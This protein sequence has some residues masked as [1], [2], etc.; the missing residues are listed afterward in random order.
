MNKKYRRTIK[1]YT[2][3]LAIL[4]FFAAVLGYILIAEY[5]VEFSARVTPSYARADITYLVQKSSWTEED[6]TLLYRQ[7]GLGKSALDALK[8]ENGDILAF[9]D[10]L[11]YE[12][13][14]EHE[15]VVFT[16]K[17][18]K[19]SYTLSESGFAPIAPLETGDVL[20][21]SA[22]HSFGWRN[23]HAAIVTDEYGT[24]LESVSLGKNSRLADSVDWFRSSP[25]FIV[26]RLKGVSKEDR[27]KIGETAAKTLNNVPYSLT[28]GIFSPKDQGPDAKET[29]CAH[30][31][32]QAYY[33]FGYDI[34]SNGGPLVVPQ[35]IALSD[36][37]EVVQVYG[38]D[39]DTLW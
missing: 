28:V 24:L 29:Q 30:L 2:V 38:F 13:E 32:W 5:T 26:L 4:L 11:F 3:F 6:Y 1:L 12:G 14:I 9:Q 33:N 34:D 18:D 22:C 17:R 36:L 31:V 37:F 23:G 7:T 19:M 8:R 15:S 27:A 25:N 10:A 39:V 20:V 16:T 21:S 35:D